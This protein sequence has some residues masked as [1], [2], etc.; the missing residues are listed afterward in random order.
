MAEPAAKQL[1]ERLPQTIVPTHYD[2]TIQPFLDKF[3]FDGSVTIHLQVCRGIGE[4]PAVLI[5]VF[6]R[7]GE[8]ANRLSDALRCRNEGRRC[9]DRFKLERYHPHVFVEHFSG[10]L[11]SQTSRKATC[12]S[13]RPTNG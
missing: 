11:I 4:C 3:T 9:N 12:N 5:K 7:A 1:F 13:T 10:C 2:L 8:T 6:F